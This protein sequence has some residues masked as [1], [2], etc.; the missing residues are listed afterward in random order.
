MIAVDTMRWPLL[1]AF[2]FAALTSLASAQ[3]APKPRAGEWGAVRVPG[4]VSALLQVAGLTPDR[5]RAS[6]MLDLIRVVHET[7]VV[8]DAASEARR[9]ALASYL[10]ALS[11]IE[12]ARMAAPEGVRIPLAE[13]KASRPAVET[14]A[15][16]LGATLE[17]E[18]GK[19]VM[20]PGGGSRA[21]QR[22]TAL[23]AAGIDASA[24]VTAFNRGE[25]I[26]VS[27][28]GDE[29]PLPLPEKSWT[30]RGTEEAARSTHVLFM[31]TPPALRGS[32]AA[33]ILSDRRASLLYYG[34]CA[35]D[36][37]TRAFVAATPSFPAAIY[38]STR[39]GSFAL[40]ARSF[41]VANGRA[42]TPGGAA[43]QPLWEKL[44]GA[45]A[46]QPAA[47][48][49]QVLE[50][51]GGRLA[52]LYDAVAQMDESRRAFVLGASL[53]DASRRLERFTAAYD[54][55]A[56]ALAGWLPAARPFSRPL[57]DPAHV[58]L[59]TPA[60]EG[61][62]PAQPSSRRLWERAFASFDIPEKP[63]D[64]LKGKDE[65]AVD[66]ADVVELVCVTNAT[67]RRDRAEAWLFGHR[68]FA[69]A[70]AA[71]MPDVLVALRGHARFRA[72]ADTLERLGITDPAVYAAAM[73]RAQR[74]AG[75]ADRDRAATGLALYQGAL[76]MIERA[77]L[78]RTVDVATAGTLVAALAGTPLSD[79]GDWR[80]GVARWIDASYLPAVGGVPPDGGAEDAVLRAFAG[81][82]PLRGPDG[83]PRVV[84]VEDVSYRIDPSAPALVRFQDVRER[85]GGWALDPVLTLSREVR[86]LAAAQSI[87]DVSS[88][89]AAI[90]KSVEAIGAAKSTGPGE[91][92]GGRVVEQLKELV[93][94][95]EKIR[96]PGDVKKAPSLASRLEGPADW[97]L[98]RTLVALA[99]TPSL[100]SEE[101]SELLA[102]DPS[103]RHDFGLADPPGE[104]RTRNPWQVAQEGHEGTG[105]WHMTGSLLALD[106]G[107]SRQAL[108]RISTDTL[109]PP[110]VIKANDRAALAEAVVLA[111][112]HD[113]DAATLT[114]L[115]D[116]LRGGRA[117]VAALAA[118]P[119]DLDAVARAARLDPLRRQLVAW[120][121][122]RDREH[123]KSFFSAGDLWSLGQE[124]ALPAA[125]RGAWGTSGWSFEGCLCLE[126][127]PFQLWSS[128]TGRYGKALIVSLVPDTTLLV[129]EA[130]EEH[131]LPAELTLSVL[132]AASQDV[133]DSL[134]PAHD[135]DWMG[136][137]AQVQAMLPARV[138]D[139]VAAAMT[140]GVLVPVQNRPDD[141]QH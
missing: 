113:Y 141:R 134:R 68:V 59:L 97:C 26:A 71:A 36:D 123:V 44:A 85:Q 106:V 31:Q 30:Y 79:D 35:M 119:A 33:A 21:E 40:Y 139:Y 128:L 67:V 75:M 93:E 12:L 65:R 56:P 91:D 110:P 52:L 58:L 7:E 90:A 28:A 37:E 14:Y 140:G 54:A 102:G 125:S 53:A 129:A 107:L 62:Q 127:P 112:V 51:D 88:R 11:A 1:S 45:Q 15:Q 118:A 10:D 114:S 122:G 130:V 101:G 94:D 87:D 46:S 50:R 17:Q 63:A 133:I 84:I 117:R 64:E 9:A 126:Y 137:V 136:M 99:Y 42:D 95:L 48:F 47:F 72:L 70:G 116:A 100:W 29:V 6:A 132:A 109:P 105:R 19:F 69:G 83:A 27:L 77:R 57:Y 92:A 38:G 13:D 32:L 74:F 55:M 96:K 104:Q 73:Q 78:S 80:G 135:D 111:N 89:A 49:L 60:A 41:R 16:A 121:L 120:S 43:F 22:R 23:Q 18:S 115:V 82:G 3:D 8:V 61:G 2:A 138:D 24:L 4:G 76:V 103:V 98:A 5:P 25:T 124:G 39:V 81:R 34:L 108:R 66:A 131:G 20:K 86:A